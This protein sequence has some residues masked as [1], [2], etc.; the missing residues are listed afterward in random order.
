MSASHKSSKVLCTLLKCFAPFRRPLVRRLPLLPL[1]RLPLP[2][3]HSPHY[4][5]KACLVRC[6]APACDTSCL[7]SS[8]SM[9][10]SISMAMAMSAG[11]SGETGRAGRRHRAARVTRESREASWGR[12]YCSLRVSPRLPWPNNRVHRMNR[13]NRMVASVC[14]CEVPVRELDRRRWRRWRWTKRS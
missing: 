9:S 3:P 5:L 7:P 4:T 12:H 10:I 14:G 8:M 2:K 1:L 11:G 6:L 13:M